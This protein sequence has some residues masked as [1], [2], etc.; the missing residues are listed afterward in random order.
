[1]RLVFVATITILC[2]MAGA[3]AVPLSSANQ[4]IETCVNAAAATDHVPAKMVD[5]GA[6]ECATADLHKILKP[7]DFDLHERMLEIIATGA[8]EK[9]FNKQMSDIMLQRGM[10]QNDV[11]A[12]LARTKAAQN[13]AQQ[14][15]DPSIMLDPT[16][17]NKSGH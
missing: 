5:R 15:C 8:D 16:T 6:C 7:G 13:K 11:D 2:G 14:D 12:F 1:M 17:P 10:K 3:Q 4:E 9:T